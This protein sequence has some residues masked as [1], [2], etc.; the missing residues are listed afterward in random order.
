MWEARSEAV[1]EGAVLDGELLELA[2]ARDEVGPLRDDALVLGEESLAALG[3]AGLGE[4]Q[5]LRDGRVD[6]VGQLANER[7]VDDARD[8]VN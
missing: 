1:R 6:G 8:I 3:R 7:E 5:R 4:A 2:L